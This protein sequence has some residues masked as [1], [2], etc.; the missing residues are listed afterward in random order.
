MQSTGPVNA[1]SHTSYASYNSNFNETV[2]SDNNGHTDAI[3][4]IRHNSVSAPRSTIHE[5]LNSNANDAN[6]NSLSMSGNSISSA[7]SPS[8]IP[9][10]G[11]IDAIT[12][13]IKPEKS[14]QT[15]PR[16][17]YRRKSTNEEKVLIS[18]SSPEG[19]A[20][21][22]QIT[23]NRIA[24]I[25]LKEGPLPIRHLTGHLI[26][27]VP[28]F[29]NLSLSKQ[30]RLIMAA[31]ESGDIDTGC[32]FEKIG[33]GQW[34]AKTV[35]IEIV[36]MKIESSNNNN[37]SF[38]DVSDPKQNAEKLQVTSNTNSNLPLNENSTRVKKPRSQSYSIRRESIS[39]HLSENYKL[40]IS[41]NFGP[42]QTFRNSVRQFGDIDDA[43]KSSSD[44]DLID[45]DEDDD[46]DFGNDVNTSYRRTA[47]LSP[48]PEHS[49]TAISG[50]IPSVSSSRRTSFA[51]ITKPRKP[52][53]S[54]SQHTIEVALDDAP[55]ER[56]ESRVSFSNSA[57]IS[58]QSF[59][60]THILPHI[61]NNTAS[62]DKDNEDAIADDFEEFKL[63]HDHS[64]PDSA[65]VIT[66][67]EDWQSQG[68]SLVKNNRQSSVLGSQNSVLQD[69][70]MKNGSQTNTNNS[71]TV[72]ELAAIALMD[73]KST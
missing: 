8:P 13:P 6:S 38:H 30:R 1:G 62:F 63:N 27:Q 35:G 52:R 49:E 16:A 33:W 56:R 57:N 50:K 31:L 4:N 12:S 28:V 59:L 66:D 34:E 71:K 51:G 69:F 64:S 22:S 73:M 53:T 17:K 36:K 15:K 7:S 44:E 29:G 54:F 24:K 47:K 67:E 21:A 14:E 20:A 26:D 32:I 9:K 10:M 45:D 72:E 68:P 19:I 23:P 3:T 55:L 46:D 42:T 58:R 61:N 11:S 2:N 18:T 39:S 37:Q 60:R 41:P 65:A 48:S 43:I 5:L 40:P 70:R 25:L